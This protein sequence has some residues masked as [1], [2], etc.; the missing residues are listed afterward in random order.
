MFCFYPLLQVFTA[1][2]PHISLHCISHV[3]YSLCSFAALSHALSLHHRV[4]PVFDSHIPVCLH[5]HSV[6]RQ[7]DDCQ[8]LQSLR[9]QVQY[10]FKH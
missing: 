5:K 10:L 8:R 1:I 2:L 4:L 6:L 9:D 7:A 3:E